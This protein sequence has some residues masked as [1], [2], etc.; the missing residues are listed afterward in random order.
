MHFLQPIYINVFIPERNMSKRYAC[1][2]ALNKSSDTVSDL[3]GRELQIVYIFF[4]SVLT[5]ACFSALTVYLPPCVCVWG[6]V[7]WPL[8]TV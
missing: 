4:R 7:V 2:P 6:G 8:P 5:R 1:V 3:S